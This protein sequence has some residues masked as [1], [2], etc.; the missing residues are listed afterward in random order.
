MKNCMH[1]FE[2]KCINTPQ[3][4]QGNEAK[5]GYSHKTQGTAYDG[6]YHCHG[7]G[8]DRSRCSCE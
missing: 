7:N 1:V 4:F 3:Q 5:K 2:N 8:G 6:S